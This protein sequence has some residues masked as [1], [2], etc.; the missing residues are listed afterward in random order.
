MQQ[1]HN[2]NSRIKILKSKNNNFNKII[3]NPVKN[4]NLIN[5]PINNN[6]IINNI[7]NNIDMNNINNNFYIHLLFDQYLHE[8]TGGYSKII[9]KTFM[10]KIHLYNQTNLNNNLNNLISLIYYSN[11]SN[12]N[13]NEQIN[14]LEKFNSI[15]LLSGY[16]KKDKSGHAI[17]IY[18]NKS[19]ILNKYNLYIFNSGEGINYHYINK[20]E[21]YNCNNNKYN[22]GINFNNITSENIFKILKFNYIFNN[23]NCSTKQIKYILD[24]LGINFKDKYEL[25]QIKEYQDEIKNIDNFY[26]LLYLYVDKNNM[27]IILNDK[28]QMSGSCSFYSSFYFIKYYFNNYKI[29]FNNFHLFLKKMQ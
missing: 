13:L 28:T 16:S 2:I 15:L 17:N 1:L 4:R 5:I 9:L 14:I 11:K 27:N 22:I 10:Y 25:Q 3:K 26:K 12:N 19:D 7:N 18:I 21:Y 20:E 8:E 24:E 6:Y 23:V 29:N